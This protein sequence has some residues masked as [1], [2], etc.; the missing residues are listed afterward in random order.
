MKSPLIVVTGATGKT[1]GAVVDHLVQKGAHV[2]AV[3][4]ARDARSERLDRLGVQTVV[5]DMFDP[6]QIYEALRG[7]QRVY[8]LPIFHPYMIQA[9]AVFAIAAREARLESIVEMGQ[10]LSHR[11]HP[12]IMTRQ[13]WLTDGLLRQ[14]PGVALT[15]LNPGMFADNF[16]RVM[17][18]ASLLGIFPVLSGAGRA[19]P[20]SNEDMARVAAAVLLD[21]A[22]HAGKTYRPTGPA[23]LSGRD[24]A[25][26]IAGV[27][28][29]RVIP[30]D[31]PF[32]LFR[33]VARQQRIDPMTISGF[34]YYMAEMKRGT[35]ELDGGVTNVL[36]ELTG[37]PAESF[38]TTARRY[39]RLPFAQPTLANR[40]KALVSFM[41]TPL[42]PGYD[43]ERWDREKGFP[44]HANPTLSIDDAQWQTT[45]AAP[46]SS[47]GAPAISISTEGSLQTPAPA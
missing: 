38:E 9:T 5:A 15:I 14:V 32:W 30:V 6:D 22:P 13:T 20:V 12:A 39:A 35:F 43:L 3:V 23:L 1:G 45:H 10:W 17:D 24:M 41:L 26:V 40:L 18:F 25:A 8:Y 36:A 11:A 28:G 37:A 7:A 31:L 46:P 34:R 27:V 44:M 42:L 21:P 2:R 16:L 4:R 19:A 47:A 33:K 29:H